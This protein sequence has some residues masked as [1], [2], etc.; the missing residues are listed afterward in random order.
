VQLK[1]FP[2][3][4]RGHIEQK[5]T[6]RRRGKEN[7]ATKEKD[8]PQAEAAIKEEAFWGLPAKGRKKKSLR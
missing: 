6:W 3:E 7:L 1:T 8:F 4:G 5:K 2:Y